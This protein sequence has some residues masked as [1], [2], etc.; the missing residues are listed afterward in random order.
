LLKTVTGGSLVRPSCIVT[1]T[2]STYPALCFCES[3]Q[4]AWPLRTATRKSF[5]AT[6]KGR[7]EVAEMILELRAVIELLPERQHEGGV[8]LEQANFGDQEIR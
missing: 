1:L 4:K 5:A 3:L 6:Y 8:G 7:A 2:V